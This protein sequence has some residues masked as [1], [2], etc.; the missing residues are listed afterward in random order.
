MITKTNEIIDISDRIHDMIYQDLVQVNHP[1]KIESRVLESYISG[2]NQK[3]L[4]LAHGEATTKASILKINQSSIVIELLKKSFKL[5]KDN[6]VLIVFNHPTYNKTFVLQTMVEKTVF[7]KCWLKYLDP[8]LYKRYKFQ[9][10][11]DLKFYSVPS[12][13]YNLIKNRQV[14]IIR[15]TLVDKEEQEKRLTLND[16]IYSGVNL[17]DP[18][19]ENLDLDA[20]NLH[21]DYRSLSE[22]PSKKASL[23]DIS[24][25]GLCIILDE[26]VYESEGLILVNIGIPSINSDDPQVV[27]NPLSLQLL[28]AIRGIS[29]INS[30]YGVHIA[31]LKRLNADFSDAI[32]SVLEKYYDYIKEPI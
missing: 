6:R 14:Q 12:K 26:E 30:K 1:Y 31:F 29:K 15:Q 13:I 10:K 8:R 18:N 24:R 4:I 27:C 17:N 11:N 25:G 3:N 23:K 21:S 32:F 20:D 28:G 19:I 9:L 5:E 7:S 16:S 2:E 22:K